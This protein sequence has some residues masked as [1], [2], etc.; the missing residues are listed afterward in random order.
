[1]ETPIELAGALVVTGCPR[2]PAA[3]AIAAP[4]KCRSGRGNY[5]EHRRGHSTRP[6]SNPKSRFGRG[7]PG[8]GG[9]RAAELSEDTERRRSGG[10]QRPLTAREVLRQPHPNTS[11]NGAAIANSARAHHR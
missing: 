4:S 1:M 8:L 7:K 3:R 11:D 6:R 5:R 10:P 9:Q 2:I